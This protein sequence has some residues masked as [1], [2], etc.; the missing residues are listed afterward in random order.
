MTFRNQQ[1]SEKPLNM[2]ESRSN[3]EFLSDAAQTQESN[4]SSTSASFCNN[5]ISKTP[6]IVNRAS[7]N[8]QIPVG[9]REQ[10]RK[11]ALL[12]ANM[13]LKKGAT[14]VKKQKMLNS[15]QQMNV[16][17]FIELERIK[18][19]SPIAVLT[20]K[21]FCMFVNAFRER[22]AE[23]EMES[24]PRIQAFI[25]SHITR[26]LSEILCNIKNKILLDFN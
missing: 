11:S 14:D 26:Y 1:E 16:G 23:E 25:V 10:E 17:V 21:M 7:K 8:V 15:F 19:P 13:L 24:W 4:E 20:A 9:Q 18:K 2:L 3:F 22:P 5:Q 12:M 6:E